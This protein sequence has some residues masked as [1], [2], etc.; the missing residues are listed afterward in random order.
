MRRVRQRLMDRPPVRTLALV[1]GAWMFVSAAACVPLDQNVSES[2]EEVAP[3]TS[4]VTVVNDGSTLT[5]TTG[6]TMG[7][8]TQTTVDLGARDAFLQDF[9][10]EETYAGAEYWGEE[11]V[12]SEEVTLVTYRVEGDRIVRP[13]VAAVPADLAGLQRDTQ[14]QSEVWDYFVSFMPAEQREPIRQYVVF[15]DG[16]D[17]VV[18]GVD[19]LT[20]DPA[21][22]ALEVDIADSTDKVDLTYTLLHEYAHALTLDE[23][24]FAGSGDG[25]STYV[26]DGER[27]REDSYLNRFYQEFWVDIYADWESAG[28]QD[29]MDGFY[30][31][32]SDQFLSDYAATDPVED[33]AES[34]MYFVLAMPPGGDSTAGRKLL[35]FYNYPD[36]VELREKIRNGLYA[37][38][39]AQ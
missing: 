7:E 31:A 5:E 6:E 20:E 29:D 30:E 37:H 18:A 36:Q 19:Q 34:W 23:D 28:E 27:T 33:I 4:E 38:L 25:G 8:T 2:G 9:F 24:Q 15:T 35:F 17:N 39:T 3:D 16:V 11:E 1:I 32:Y 12:E 10:A 22:W 26:S 14:T 21:T 13:E